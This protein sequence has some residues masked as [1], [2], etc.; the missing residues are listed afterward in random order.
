MNLKEL[1]LK[2][3]NSEILTTE[4]LDL[5]WELKSNPTNIELKSN[6]I[7]IELKMEERKMWKAIDLKK[8]DDLLIEY[9]DFKSDN[10]IFSKFI[11]RTTDDEI[12]VWDYVGSIGVI[13][14]QDFEN[15]FD[16]D[17]IERNF[18][19]LAHFWFKGIDAQVDYGMVLECV[20]DK[21]KHFKDT[22]K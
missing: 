13:T 10:E 11:E 18:E 19:D 2:L 8:I 9:G 17:F 3:Q 6:P 20:E 5:L 4:E 1:E 7:N 15:N 22:L 12:P 14:P 16:K 21:M